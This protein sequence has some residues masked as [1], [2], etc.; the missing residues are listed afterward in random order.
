MWSENRSQDFNFDDKIFNLNK[1]HTQEYLLKK[2]IM[3]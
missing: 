3:I 2:H 1:T